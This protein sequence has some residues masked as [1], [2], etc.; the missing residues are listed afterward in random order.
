MIGQEAGGRMRL[1]H[2]L[3]TVRSSLRAGTEMLARAG[4]ESPRLD[5]EVLLATALSGRRED[6]YIDSE[7]EMTAEQSACYQR[8]LARR[9]R[10]E[11]VAYIVGK[12]V[13]VPKL[14]RDSGVLIPRPETELLVELALKSF[15]H[16]ELCAARQFG[17]SIWAQ[18]RRDC[19]QPGKGETM[20]RFGASTWRARPWKSPC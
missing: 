2:G 3:E 5:A 16:H 20:W 4:V 1:R 6:L 19:R 17:C 13:L 10:R 9:M 8:M 11:P 18:E 7:T 15:N 14:C 12:R